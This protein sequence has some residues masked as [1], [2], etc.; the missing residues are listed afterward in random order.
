MNRP[1]R[2]LL[3]CTCLTLLALANQAD[4]SS[5][6]DVASLK[7]APPPS[8][9]YSVDL[10]NSSHGRL[11]LTNVTLSECL[12]YAFKIH[13]DAQISGPEWI[14]DHSILFNI[15]GQAPPDTPR[16]E[17]R[18]MALNLLVERFRMAWH[19]ES[20]QL[21]YLALTVD[22]SGLKM[23]ESKDGAP[24]GREIVRPGQIV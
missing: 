9:R 12:R 15:V 8:G 16:D 10:G 20:R 11:T 7:P 21:S 19:Q 17:L 24:A 5:V 4:K 3:G 1:L 22:K 2:Y 6:F 18:R 13:T 14:K 23:P